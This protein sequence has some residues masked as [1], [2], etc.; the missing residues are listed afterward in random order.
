LPWLRV[1]HFLCDGY[2]A[3]PW[4]MKS[5]VKHNMLK[6]IFTLDRTCRTCFRSGWRVWDPLPRLSLFRHHTRKP[7][8]RHPWRCS[9]Q[10][11]HQHLHGRQALCADIN[12][13]VFLIFTQPARHKFGCNRMRSK[14]WS[15]NALSRDFLYS[16]FLCYLA[17]AQT[18]IGTNNF[19]NVLEV[20]FVIWCLKLVLN[21]NCPELKFGSL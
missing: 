14:I 7:K 15:K 16:T 3:W 20:F 21:V 18:T 10:S 17:N 5:L 2:G 19:S 8:F 1:R 6:T 12:T 13:I 11:F 9:L 4:W